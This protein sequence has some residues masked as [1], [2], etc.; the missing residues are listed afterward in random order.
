MADILKKI[1]AYKRKEIVEAKLRMPLSTLERRIESHDPPRG[2]V[3]AIEARLAEGRFALIAEIKKASPSKGLIRADFDPPVLAKAYETGG[4]ACLSVL[5]DTPSFQ[6]SLDYLEAARKAVRLPALRKDFLF[7]P[8]QVYEARAYGADCILIIMACVTDEEAK[9]I[10]KTAHDLRL[11]VLVEV[12]DEAELHRALELETKLL[13]INNRDLRT[14]ETKL[15]TC[16]RLAEKIPADRIVVAES[17]IASHDDCLRLHKSGIDTFLVGES[18]M[19]QKDVTAATHTLL[20]GDDAERHATP[21]K[22]HG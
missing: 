18:L 22:A 14:F 15:E 2:F 10:N 3:H 8:Y 9:R 6:G 12:H 16:E 13:G 20:C 4:A 7:D 19:R 17:G 21:R 11:D 5:T 1:E